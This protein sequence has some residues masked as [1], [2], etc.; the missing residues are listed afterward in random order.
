MP[1]TVLL[2]ESDAEI[3]DRLADAL[4]AKGHLV[5]RADSLDEARARFDADKPNLVVADWNLKGGS[6][7]DLV[8]SVR[9]SGYNAWVPILVTAWREDMARQLRAAIEAGA[10]DCIAKPVDAELFDLKI[11]ALQ[12]FAAV[13]SGLRGIIDNV[14]EGIVVIDGSGIVRSFNQAAELVF[15]YAAAEVVGA[16]VRMLMPAPY[17]DEHDGYIARYLDTHEPKVIGTGRQVVGLRKSGET[18]PMRLAVTAVRGAAAPTFIG[19][20]HDLSDEREQER[21]THLALHDSLTGLPNRAHFVAALDD[22]LAAVESGTAH[23][24]A[25]LFID[26]D[27]FKAINDCL[28]H[29]VG[30]AVLSTI[31]GRLK[32]SVSRQDMVA[33]LAGDE[34]V[35]LLREVDD[36]SLAMTIARRLIDAAGADMMLAGTRLNVAISVGVTLSSHGPRSAAELL[37]RAD[38]AMYDAKRSGGATAHSL[39]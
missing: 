23:E 24:F 33:R 2:S 15:G 34:F 21:L 37:A 17:R 32:H 18:F 38:A 29:A 35:A 26:V 6:G 5:I 10:D 14:L 13:Q 30:D 27:H 8:R 12:R 25:L 20:V 11:L 36:A 3:A 7:L 22:L 31:A 28:G 1:L 4:A 39:P 19:L 9:G 16:N